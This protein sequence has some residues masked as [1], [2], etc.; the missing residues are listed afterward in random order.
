M[1]SCCKSSRRLR[2]A[3][4]EFVKPR[5]SSVSKASLRSKSAYD[6]ESTLVIRLDRALE[7]PAVVP[8]GDV[9]PVV[10]DKMSDVEPLRS[11]K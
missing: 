6:V 11:R 10:G 7:R 4:C 3:S 9:I 8:T 1:T 2:L 5:E